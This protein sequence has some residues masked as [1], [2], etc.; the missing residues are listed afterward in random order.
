MSEAHQ[1][2]IHYTRE[3]ARRLLPKVK[4]WLRKLLRLN[5]RLRQAGAKVEQL[6]SSG[7]DRGGATVEEYLRLQSDC[8]EILRAFEKRQILV[9]DLGRGLVDFPAILDGREIFL[10]WEQGEEDI[11][12]WHEIDAGYAGRERF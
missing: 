4:E 6:M 7:Q 10:C 12:F 9:K 2:S 1:F 3:E 5:E 8:L 11:E